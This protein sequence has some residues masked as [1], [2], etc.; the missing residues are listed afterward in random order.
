MFSLIDLYPLF[1]DPYG[2]IP[3]VQ[4]GMV[5]IAWSYCLGERIKD[6]SQPVSFHNGI[7]TVRVTNAQ[8]QLALNPMKHEILRKL[9]AYLTKSLVNDLIIEV[10]PRP[11]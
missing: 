4:E 10:Q 1:A 8:W 5:R 9:N 2:T 6:I 7:L 11:F 3:E